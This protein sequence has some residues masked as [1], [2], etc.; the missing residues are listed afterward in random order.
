MI[1]LLRDMEK[2][3]TLLI[4][5]VD[6]SVCRVNTIPSPPLL[7][8]YLILVFRHSDIYL[9]LWTIIFLQHQKEKKKEQM[10]L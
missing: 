4:N 7:R 5:S 6:Y 1:K 9:K 3:L 8:V 10:T 2:K